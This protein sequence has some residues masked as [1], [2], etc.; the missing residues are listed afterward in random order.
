MSYL[1]Q[2][3]SHEKLSDKQITCSPFMGRGLLGVE[4]PFYVSNF[5]CW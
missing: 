4:F 3:R 2:I 5:E 1:S